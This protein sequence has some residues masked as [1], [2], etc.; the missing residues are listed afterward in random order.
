MA[1][2]PDTTT[3]RPDPHRI[4]RAQAEALVGL[5]WPALSK[6]DNVL[7][8][9]PRGTRL[10]GS[11]AMIVESAIPGFYL[12]D[13]TNHSAPDGMHSVSTRKPVWGSETSAGVNWVWYFATTELGTHDVETTIRKDADWVR[14]MR[15]DALADVWNDSLYELAI[16]LVEVPKPA[17]VQHSLCLGDAGCTCAA[18]TTEAQP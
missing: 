14:R 12:V 2:M 11:I 15:K 4:R 6:G 13:V 18:C 17:V 10:T 8:A 3:T 9:W 1:T 5:Q 7:W 16:G